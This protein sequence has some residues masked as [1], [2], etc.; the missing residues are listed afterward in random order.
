MGLEGNGTTHDIGIGLHDV[1]AVRKH[2]VWL[3]KVPLYVLIDVICGLL[4]SRQDLVYVLLCTLQ[5]LL[6]IAASLIL[7][8]LTREIEQYGQG[9]EKQQHH[10]AG[11]HQVQSE[12]QVGNGYLI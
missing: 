7:Q 8:R 11:H 3:V 12:R 4:D 6:G 2:T 10:L 5:R 1:A 9:Q